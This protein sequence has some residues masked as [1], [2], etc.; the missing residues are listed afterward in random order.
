MTKIFDLYRLNWWGK[1]V[2]GAVS[3]GF[4]WLTALA[5]GW[6][7]HDLD[8]VGKGRKEK[9]RGADWERKSLFFFSL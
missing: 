3:Y 8:L 4:F 2:G 1:K 6:I 7:V 9:D 5:I